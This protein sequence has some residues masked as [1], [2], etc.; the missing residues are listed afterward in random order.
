LLEVPDVAEDGFH[1]DYIR[2][3]GVRRLAYAAKV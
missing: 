2:E 1:V 3:V